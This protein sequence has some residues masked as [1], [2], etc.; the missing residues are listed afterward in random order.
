MKKWILFILILIIV[1]TGLLYFF[2]P[3][4]VLILQSSVIPVNAKGFSRTIVDEKKWNQWWPGEILHNDAGTAHFRYKGN[5]YTIIEKRMSSVI[6][7][8]KDGNDSFRTEL[9]FIPV[10]P[11]SVVLNW[12]GSATSSILPVNR[13]RLYYKG[14][15]LNK[16]L[17]AILQH[18]QE[19]YEKEE[20]IYGLTIKK[21]LV[22]DSTLI[23]TAATSRG[24]P[25]IEFIYG[26]IDKL[27]IYAERNGAKQTGLPMLNINT[28]DGIVYDTRVAMPVDKRLKDSGSIAY[29][30]M[31][32][33]G[34]ILMTE[35]KGGPYTIKQAFAEMENYV[36]DFQRT[37]PA[38]PFQSLITD[39]R[40]EP[41]T[42]RW[43]TR[44]FWPVM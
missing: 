10:T 9:L 40:K 28:A 36:H 21:D 41:D 43:I 5:T 19:F 3:T 27:K 30:W 6:V 23:S 29:R 11:D 15:N 26:L 1:A 24:Y 14:K 12:E 44:L 35:V 39:R 7:G 2:I 32:G 8:V 34:N 31:L 42:S 13:L 33:G 16:D 37:A 22:V 25:T 18:I 38:I 4:S 20:N 17:K